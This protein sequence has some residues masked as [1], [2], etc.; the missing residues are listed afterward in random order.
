MMN[1]NHIRGF[2]F[3]TAWV[4]LGGIL[5]AQE[6]YPFGIPVFS[7]GMLMVGFGLYVDK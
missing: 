2:L 1:Y 5:I 6:N 3:G 7:A 4:V